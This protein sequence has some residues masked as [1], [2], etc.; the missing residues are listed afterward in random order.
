MFLRRRCQIERLEPRRLLSGVTYQGGRLIDHAAVEAVF[1]GRGWTSDPAL[2]QNAAQLDQFFSTITNS[3]FMDML[4][5][6]G[7]AQGGPIGRGSFTGQVTLSQDNWRAGTISDGMI[8]SL[9]DSEIISRAIARPSPNQ[10]LFVF[11]PPNVAVTKDGSS[12]N[13]RPV[14]FAGYHDSFVDSQGDT[15]VYAVI[16]NPVGNDRIPG[17]TAFEQQTEAASHELAEA[18]T[19]PTRNGWWDDTGDSTS[20]LEIA[21]FANPA[22][23][24][25]YLGPYAVERVWSNRL[26]GLESPAGSTSAPN[27]SPASGGGGVGSPGGAIPPEL[28]SVAVAFTQVLGYYGAVVSRA[29]HDYIGREPDDAG[30]N[31][32]VERMQAGLSEEQLDAAFIGSP[33][34][35]RDHGGS[36]PAWVTGMYH[37]L[38]GRSPDAQGLQYWTARLQSGESHFGVA[39]GFAASPER[40]ALVIDG[41]YRELLGRPASQAETASWVN[42]LASGVG[43]DALVA[44]LIG[45]AEYFNDPD[46]GAGND[47][48]WVGS[49]YHDLFAMSAPTGEERYWVSRL[50]P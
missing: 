12:S 40:E 8:H 41:D 42:Q 21:D 18:I 33:E 14:G 16:P 30:L 28:G 39:L 5:E 43:R 48:A 37:D 47:A 34:Y 38:L 31:Y 1:L 46:K 36:D 49:V 27:G 32:W 3:T 35:V 24:V 22:T 10:L 25:V 50:E 23:D 19:N 13:G 26:H 15:V 44:A 45:S 20:G 29:Y 7:T 6:Y 11:T 2:A 4:A 9:L 17:R